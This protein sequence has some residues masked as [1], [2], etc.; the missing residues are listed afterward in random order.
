[1]RVDVYFYLS[2]SGEYGCKIVLP[3]GKVG[4][5]HPNVEEGEMR[6]HTHHDFH[7]SKVVLALRFASEDAR[8]SIAKHELIPFMAAVEMMS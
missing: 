1:M 3:S 8:N 4:R 5:S 2:Q 7:D 6:N